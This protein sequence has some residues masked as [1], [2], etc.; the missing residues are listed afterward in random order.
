[1]FIPMAAHIYRIYRPYYGHWQGQARGN[2]GISSSLSAQCR[3]L[4][5]LSGDGCGH[6]TVIVVE[7]DRLWV[8][9]H[10]YKDVPVIR[11]DLSYG[12]FSVVLLEVSLDRIALRQGQRFVP[13]KQTYY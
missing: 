1:M 7:L 10:S 12:L 4:L 8:G 13:E 11:R 6:F 2:E 3:S 5:Y 9:F